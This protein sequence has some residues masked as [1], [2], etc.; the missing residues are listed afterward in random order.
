MILIALL[1][2]AVYGVAADDTLYYRLQMDA[3][4]LS[5]AGI[6]DEDLRELDVRL[7]LYLFKPMNADTAFDNSEIEVFGE[8][9]PPFNERELIHLYDCRKLLS[10]TGQGSTYIL[11][12]A[13]GALLLC[14]GGRRAGKRLGAL[15]LSAAL[16]LLP[17]LALGIWAAVDFGS[18]F[19]FFHELL[20]TNDLWLLNPETDLLIRIC[21]SSMFMNMGLRIGLCA[22]ATLLGFPL[23]AMLT[24]KLY[25]RK[26][27]RNEI[28]DL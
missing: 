12:L 2:G 15:W 25:K 21:P 13:A 20:F 19:T 5:S 7:S 1:M 26:K 10:I 14:C 3:D 22:G 8:M 28:A 17:V 23:L 27:E 4:I 6:S 11:L 18:A 9:Q 24:V 16:V